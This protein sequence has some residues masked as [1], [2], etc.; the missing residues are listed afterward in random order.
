VNATPPARAL[1]WALGLLD[2]YW[3]L[4]GFAVVVALEALVS[5]PRGMMEAMVGGGIV[6]AALLLGWLLGTSA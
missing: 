3:G 5:A 2:R 1:V 6:G 4:I